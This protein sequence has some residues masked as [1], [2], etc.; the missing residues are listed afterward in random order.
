MSFTALLPAVLAVVPALLMGFVTSWLLKRRV[1]PIAAGRGGFLA[2]FAAFVLSC[3]L[4]HPLV[5]RWGVRMGG[6]QT[7]EQAAAAGLSLKLPASA[8]N[9]DFYFER[10]DLVEV[11]FSVSYE[12]I[13]AWAKAKGWELRE[14]NEDI[15]DIEPVN[16]HRLVGNTNS[17]IMPRDCLIYSTRLRN[18]G[19]GILLEY[20]QAIGRAYYRFRK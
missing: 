16:A 19:P 2:G 3:V 6:G 20:D 11:D 5:E 12:E 7:P 17:H 9:V 13:Q 10:G 1:N 14:I 15:P 8:K 18:D 4:L